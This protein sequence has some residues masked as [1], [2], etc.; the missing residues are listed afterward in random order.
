MW[1]RLAVSAVVVGA[2]IAVITSVGHIKPSEV[3]HTLE[4]IGPR[5]AGF[6]LLAVIAQMTFIMTRLWFLFP[7]PRP[8]WARTAH[9]FSLGQV[10]NNFLPIRSG[11]VVKVMLITS[12]IDV[13][14]RSVAETFGVLIADSLVDISALALLLIIVGPGDLISKGSGAWS[15]LALV[16]LLIVAVVIVLLVVRR[17]P[18]VRRVLEGMRALRNPL[19]ILGGLALST[20]NWTMEFVALHFLAAE[21]GGDLGFVSAIRVLFLFNL[22]IVLPL[23]VA[24]IGTFEGSIAIGLAAAGMTFADGLAIGTA[25]HGLQILGVVALALAMVTARKLW[26]TRFRP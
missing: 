6:A 18:R 2:I 10:V 25:Y 13:T 22:G 19:K 11:D 21:L 5:A 8:R 23:S 16:G 24:N 7:S 26:P 14:K 17:K 9:A 20:G 3:I 15:R 12:P 4:R 1:V